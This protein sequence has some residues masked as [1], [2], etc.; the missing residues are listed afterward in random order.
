MIRWIG[1][2]DWIRLIDLI[3]LI[4]LIGLIALIGLIGWIGLSDWVRWIECIGHIGIGSI[5]VLIV[6]SFGN[7]RELEISRSCNGW[8]DTNVF[9]DA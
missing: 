9:G 3:G 2:I 6:E 1:L 4:V 8:M 7:R 5:D